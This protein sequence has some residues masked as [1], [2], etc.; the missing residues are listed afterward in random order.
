MVKA[1]EILGAYIG[2]GAAEIQWDKVSI[3]LDVASKKVA[4][5]GFGLFGSIPF[6]NSLVFSKAGWMAAIVRPSM[7][8]LRMEG[9][10]RQRLTHGPWQAIPSI[11]LCNLK[12][13]GFCL[14]VNDLSICSIAGRARTALTTA[15]SLNACMTQIHDTLQSFERVLSIPEKVWLENSILYGMRDAIEAVKTKAPSLYSGIF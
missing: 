4:Q 13:C 11:F 14:E 15:H 1:I 8:I 7:K 9:K 6:Y 12:T 5:L 3:G 2:P 10:V